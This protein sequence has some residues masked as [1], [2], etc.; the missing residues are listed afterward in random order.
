MR[1]IAR[2]LDKPTFVAGETRLD[3]FSVEPIELGVGGF[4]V[5]F[6]ERGIA[7]HVSRQDGR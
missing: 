7:H 4:L 1:S 5:A 3:Q 2:G 6:H